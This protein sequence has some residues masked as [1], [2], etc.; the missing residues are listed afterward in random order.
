MLDPLILR[1]IS[2]GEAGSLERDI[3]P[4]WAGSRLF[5]H[6]FNDALFVDMGTPESYK[7]L[8]GLLKTS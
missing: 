7:D 6:I 1:S 8:N 4:V 2:T 3:F 5:G